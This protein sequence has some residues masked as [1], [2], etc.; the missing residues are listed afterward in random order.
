MK[1]SAALGYHCGEGTSVLCQLS[2]MEQYLSG[3]VLGELPEKTAWKNEKKHRKW[4]LTALKTCETSAIL[5]KNPVI[6]QSG[7]ILPVSD[8][9]KDLFNVTF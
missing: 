4:S 8:W 9:G 1:V 6:L 2:E 5:Q 7:A 3:L